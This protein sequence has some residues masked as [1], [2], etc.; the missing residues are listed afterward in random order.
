LQHCIQKN[1]LNLQEG[2][3]EPAW[4]EVRSTSDSFGWPRFVGSKR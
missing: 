2:Q 1:L 3:Y 4:R